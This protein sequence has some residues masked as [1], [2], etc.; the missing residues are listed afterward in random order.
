MSAA[1]TWWRSRKT[2]T[3]EALPLPPK[4]PKQSPIDPWFWDDD[5]SYFGH[6]LEVQLIPIR[7]VD[8]FWVVAS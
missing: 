1:R 2:P 3:A 7:C 6:F 5:D 4:Y 8:P